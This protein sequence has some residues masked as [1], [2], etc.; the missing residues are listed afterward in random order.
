MSRTGTS[1]APNVKK[2]SRRLIHKASLIHDPLSQQ[3]LANDRPREGGRSPKEELQVH[4][5][6]HQEQVGYYMW[7][8][9]VRRIAL[10]GQSQAESL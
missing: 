2:Q 5:V 6:D 7:Y 8:K 4:Y 9:P 10:H 3:W 1:A